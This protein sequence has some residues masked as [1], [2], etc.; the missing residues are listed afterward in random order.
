L[1]SRDFFDQKRFPKKLRNDKAMPNSVQSDFSPLSAASW[2]NNVLDTVGGHSMDR[3]LNLRKR[4]LASEF[5]E[6]T[7]VSD[8]HAAPVTMKQPAQAS[9]SLVAVSESLEAI[10]YEPTRHVQQAAPPAPPAPP[11]RFYRTFWRSI[12]RRMLQ[13]GQ[14]H[15]IRVEHPAIH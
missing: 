14:S 6:E 12:T 1:R 8:C 4:T 7:L 3:S 2:Q 10:N 11:K 5:T 9:M 15:A 13:A